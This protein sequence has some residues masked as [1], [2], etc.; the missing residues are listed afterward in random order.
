MGHVSVCVCV[1]R[2]D[3]NQFYFFFCIWWNRA[4][5]TLPP[6]PVFAY[7]VAAVRKC[8]CMLCGEWDMKRTK[9]CRAHLGHRGSRR[10]S[11]LRKRALDR[12]RLQTQT[13]KYR[14]IWFIQ[15]HQH[16]NTT[17]HSLTHSPTMASF[18]HMLFRLHTTCLTLTLPAQARTVIFRKERTKARSASPASERGMAWLQ[19][20]LAIH[21][22]VDLTTTQWACQKLPSPATRGGRPVSSTKSELDVPGAALTGSSSCLHSDW[23]KY[24]QLWVLR[25][26]KI[27]D[28]WEYICALHLW[29]IFAF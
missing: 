15:M 23:Q 11:V 22:Q 26:N 1:E 16:L 13:Y 18:P 29:L 10:V 25:Q 17:T 2:D 27:L 19:G 4:S 21:E 12:L 14:L 5:S 28:Q 9:R 24:H 20:H 7:S 6:F 8:L 3:P